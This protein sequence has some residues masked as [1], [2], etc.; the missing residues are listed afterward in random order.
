MMMILAVSA[1]AQDRNLNGYTLVFSDEFNTVDVGSHQNKGAAKWGD[2]IP[3]SAAAFSFSHWMGSY[4]ALIPDVANTQDGVLSLWA[5]WYASLNDPNGR[6]WVSGVLASKDV[7]NNGFAQRFGYWSA[8]M[9]MPDAGQGAWSAF[10][11]ASTS[12][13]PNAGTKGYEVDIIEG[14]GGQFKL[15]PGG[16]EY[17]W[18]LHPW[19]ADGSQAPPPYE[20]GAWVAVPGGDAI[21]AWHVYGCEVNPANI[22]FY[23]D[24]QEVG[25][26][27][28]HAEYIVDPLYIILNYAMQNDHSGQP[29]ASHGPSALQVDWVRAYELPQGITPPTNLRVQ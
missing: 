25:R 18:V 7:Q 12:G 8:R 26:K 16:D 13:I 2:Y 4:P 3:N 1:H 27:P 23:C 24:G 6:N 10:W 9:K 14:Y 20:G 19:N 28:T 15:G 5:K 17:N 11:L 29:F 22:I 21:G